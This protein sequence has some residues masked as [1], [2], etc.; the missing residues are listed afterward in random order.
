MER[1]PLTGYP[2]PQYEK[3][4]SD[5]GHRYRAIVGKWCDVCV[6][7]NYAYRIY[8]TGQSAALAAVNREIRYGRLVPP[9]FFNC[10]DCGGQASL[11]EHRDYN[12]P[13]E[14]V[15][16]CRSCNGKRGYA[17]P[18]KMTFDAFFELVQNSR[19]SGLTR[20]NLD[21]IRLKHFQDQA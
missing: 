16:A 5:C 19:Y 14:V 15:P 20:E 1:R 2:G 7:A 13:L 9:D 3:N 6:I 4:C 11:Y 12:K 8:G 18:K 17:I 21:F 10:V